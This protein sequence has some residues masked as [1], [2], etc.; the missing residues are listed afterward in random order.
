MV[1]STRV[2]I[3]RYFICVHRLI[4]PSIRPQPLRSTL[5]AF[6]FPP[7]PLIPSVTKDVDDAGKSPAKDGEIFP[8]DEQVS[9]R[10][11]WVAFLIVLGWAILA[12]LG[13]LPLYLV[14]TPCVANSTP[15]AS[16]G[17]AYS[18]LQDLSL[19]RLL[20]LLENGNVTKNGLQSRAFVNSKDVAPNTRIRI[21]ILTVLAIV[22]GVLPA[23]WKIVKEFN[24][25]VNYR[26]R[27]IEFRCEGQDLGWLSARK[28]PGFDGWGE[29]RIKEFILKSGLSSSLDA[30][31]KKESSQAQSRRTQEPTLTNGEKAGLEVDIKNLFSISY[32]WIDLRYDNCHMGILTRLYFMNLGIPNSSRFS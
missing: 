13:A 25:V 27:W 8:A 20:Q 17:G 18:T 4:I 10:S 14:S 16:F 32:V 30:N 5:W 24:A 6:L 23:L 2:S 29:R 15:P 3:F 19:L 12:C 26:R 21:I 22:L 1:R 28:A 7:V 11:L 9:Q 31:G